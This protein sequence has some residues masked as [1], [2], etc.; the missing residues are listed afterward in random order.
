MTIS[1]QPAGR[2]GPASLLTGR[3][4]QKTSNSS[5]VLDACNELILSG[6]RP[7]INLVAERSGLSITTVNRP[8]YKAYLRS[9]RMRHDL[10]ASGR[11]FD[12]ALAIIGETAELPVDDRPEGCDQADR[13][14][15]RKIARLTAEL[16][17]RDEQLYYTLGLVDGFRRKLRWHRETLRDLTIKL[18]ALTS[19]P[20]PARKPRKWQED[21]AS[22]PFGEVGEDDDEDD[23]LEDDGNS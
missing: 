1:R 3:N 19:E 2:G 6:T 8:R 11:T 23:D 7:S 16:E 5:A 20:I 15:A 18:D 17:R 14:A 21:M 4:D 22:S 12:E 13:Q 10:V 9:A